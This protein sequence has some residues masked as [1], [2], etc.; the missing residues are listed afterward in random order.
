MGCRQEAKLEKYAPDNSVSEV[1]TNAVWHQ[2]DW[3]LSRL[4][5]SDYVRHGELD[6]QQLFVV[7]DMKEM[8]ENEYLKVQARVNQAALTGKEFI[9]P[10][11][12]RKFLEKITY[13][14]YFLDFET[15]QDADRVNKQVHY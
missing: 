1:G 6:I 12:I 8:V 4:L 5:N 15:M 14:I 7:N 3:H 9:N 11:G 10:A 13:P 2:C